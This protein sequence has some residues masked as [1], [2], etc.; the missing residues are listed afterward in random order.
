MK[1]AYAA[2]AALL[3]FAFPGVARTQR[4]PPIVTT[5]I[6]GTG[7]PGFAGGPAARATFL[8]PMGLAYDKQGNLYI[9]DAGAQ[10]IRVLNRRGIVSTLAGGGAIDPRGPWVP[11]AYR[12]GSGSAA[13]F[14]RPTGVAV[15]ANGIVYVADSNNHCIRRID[16]RGRVTTFAGSPSAAGRDDGFRTAARFGAPTG[17][18]IDAQGDLYVADPMSAVRRIDTQGNVTTILVGTTPLGVAV[19]S[20]PAGTRIFAAGISGLAL[21]AP[22]ILLVFPSAEARRSGDPFLQGYK[23]IG[24]SFNVAY[25]DPSSLVYTDPR[26]N[27]VRYLQTDLSESRIIGGQT[28]NDASGDTGAFRDGPA[29]D[30]F[31]DAPTGIAVDSHGGVVVADSGNRRIRRIAPIERR[32]LVVASTGLLPTGDAPAGTYNIAFVGNS[33]IWQNAEWDDSIE[34][35]MERQLSAS[36]ASTSLHSMKLRPSILPIAVGSMISAAD[37]YLQV[38]NSISHTYDA[39]VFD[40]NEVTVSQSFNIPEEQVGARAAEW[41]DKLA[42]Q[43]RRF[44]DDLQQKGIPLIVVTHPMPYQLSPTEGAWMV[45]FRPTMEPDTNVGDAINASLQKAGVEVVNLWPDFVTAEKAPDHPPLFMSEDPHFTEHGRAIVATGAAAALER[46][47][48][49]TKRP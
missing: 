46:L 13:R 11:G 12:D 40:V 4:L 28:L 48:P 34:A 49:W 5:T 32:R 39:V 25:L 15:D 18:A 43:L 17:I 8:L 6:A 20:T 29:A 27:T 41:S 14:N 44:R 7:V 36:R 35:M 45:M 2:L 9:A 30:T 31:F 19:A 23:L 42:D 33:F 47:H 16:K 10:R 3:I 38:L 24:D 22:N 26:T 21:K 37:Q 1:R